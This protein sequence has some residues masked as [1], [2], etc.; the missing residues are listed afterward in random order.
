MQH[1]HFAVAISGSQ[2]TCHFDTP[3]QRDCFEP[4]G[5][6]A[7]GQNSNFHFYQTLCFV[8]NL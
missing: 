1:G 3:T 5:R 4:A 6:I 8:F 7:Q 2:K